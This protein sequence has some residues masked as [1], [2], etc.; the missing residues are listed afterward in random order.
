MSKNLLLILFFFI[1]LFIFS[2]FSSP[3]PFSVNSVQSNKADAFTVDGTGKRTG[4]PDTATISLGVTKT[5]STV[6][7]A[8]NQT[9]TAANKIISDL[10]NLGIKEKDI[11]T[12]NY[13]I[14]PEYSYISTNVYPENSA[15]IMP[16]RP[17]SK[18]TGYTVTENLYVKIRPIDKANKIVNSAAADGANLVGQ[19]NFT[20]N[21]DEAKK[22]EQ[23]AREDA[24][25]D[26]KQK[27]E[28]LAKAAGISLGRIIDIRENNNFPR[29]EKSLNAISN[30]GG[31]QETS[32]MPGESTVSITVTLSYETR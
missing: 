28:G 23:Q 31:G 8:Q 27:A 17:S 25:R 22:L 6:L 21:D 12:T 1:C 13:S 32:L 5:A 16:I 15:A 19:V 29:I 26:A 10:K 3:I 18:I 24:V 7:E 14:N 30:S 11:T 2:R 20:L 4:I 9:N